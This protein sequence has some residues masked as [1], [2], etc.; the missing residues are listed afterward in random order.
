MAD[1]LVISIGRQFGSGGREIGTLVAKELGIAFYDKEILAGAAKKSGI[2]QEVFENMDEKPT[3]SLLY[4]LSM[5]GSYAAPLFYGHYTDSMPTSDRLFMWQAQTIRQFAQ[6]GPCVI[7]GRCADY[8]LRDSTALV[9]VFIHANMDVRAARIVRL[10]NLREDKARVLIRKTDKSRANY[11]NFST[12]RNWGAL[13]NYD[14]CLDSGK[15]GVEK[16]AEPNCQYVRMRQ[17]FAK[18]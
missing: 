12:D 11:Y 15:L 18:G 14:L 1:N 2:V 8:I 17:E 16:S 5:G 9:S 3:S 13:E 4:S 6:E 10:Y 7:I